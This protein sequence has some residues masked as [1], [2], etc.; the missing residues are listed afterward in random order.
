MGLNDVNIIR[1][2]Y[3]YRSSFYNVL[4]FWFSGTVEVWTQRIR[5]LVG[6]QFT[7]N[8]KEGTAGIL[9]TSIKISSS[10]CEKTAFCLT[11]PNTC[12]IRVH[13]FPLVLVQERTA[14]KNNFD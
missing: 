14:L 8:I 5:R 9:G 7:Q 10:T 2:L 1:I 6:S 11:L 13:R 4:C 3:V 12:F